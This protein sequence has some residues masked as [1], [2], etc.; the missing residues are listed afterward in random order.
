MRGLTTIQRFSGT[1]FAAFFREVRLQCRTGMGKVKSNR[2]T[3]CVFRDGLHVSADAGK[4][5]R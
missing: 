1:D 3:A 4:G 2:K 5:W